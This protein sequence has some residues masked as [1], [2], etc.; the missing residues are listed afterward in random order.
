MLDLGICYESV[1][2][3]DLYSVK[4]KIHSLAV[5]N[6]EEEII[7]KPKFRTYITFKNT[8]GTESYVTNNI[9]SRK[10]S[11]LSQCRI[12]ILPIHVE[13]GLFRNLPVDSRVCEICRNGE[14][15]DEKRFICECDVY[16]H[17]REELYTAAGQKCTEFM[18]MDKDTKFKF[19]MKN[20]W[21]EVS[22]FLIKACDKRRAILYK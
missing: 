12:G 7:I 11:L 9:F 1:L 3:C 8:F 13:T 2:M 16:C 6:W 20:M 17:F 18:I 5:R 19:L 15:E 4:N 22:S 10:R 21:R 14:V